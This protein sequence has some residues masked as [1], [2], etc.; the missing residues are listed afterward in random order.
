M[1]ACAGDI[2]TSEALA[3]VAILREHCP[4]LKDPV[5]QCRRSVPADAGDASTLTG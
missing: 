2:P 4:A 1:I 5:H 3:A